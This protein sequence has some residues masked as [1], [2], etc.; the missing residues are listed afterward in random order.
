MQQCQVGVAGSSDIEGLRAAHE[1]NWFAI[2]SYT[3][4]YI[5]FEGDLKCFLAHIYFGFLREIE[6][7]NFFCVNFIKSN[8][9]FFGNARRRQGAIYFCIG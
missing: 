9:F 6:R 5:T 7:E 4:L 2:T 1:T 8:A 3:A